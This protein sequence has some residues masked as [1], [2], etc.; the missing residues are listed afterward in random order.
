[1]RNKVLYMAIN[2]C[3]F[4]H[5]LSR[6]SFDEQTDQNTDEPMGQRTDKWTKPFIDLLVN[7]KGKEKRRKQ[8]IDRDLQTDTQTDRQTAT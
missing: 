2:S 8:T 6:T 4:S 5:F 1:M 3:A 7:D